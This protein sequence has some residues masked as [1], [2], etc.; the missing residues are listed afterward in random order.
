MCLHNSLITRVAYF[1]CLL[2]E[3]KMQPEGKTLQNAFQRSRSISYKW[4]INMLESVPTPLIIP[5]L[6]LDPALICNAHSTLPVL[7]QWLLKWFFRRRSLSSADTENHFK[8]HWLTGEKNEVFFAFLWQVVTYG[9]YCTYDTL[10]CRQI[11]HQIM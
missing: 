4:M 5:N 9:S 1:F 3:N 2:R 6:I 11:Y 10:A 8:S 7:C